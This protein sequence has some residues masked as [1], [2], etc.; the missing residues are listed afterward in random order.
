MSQLQNTAQVFQ[1]NDLV[2]AAKLNA[3]VVQTTITPEVITAQA[4][5]SPAL[6]GWDY[7]LAYEE[8]SGTLVKVDIDTIRATGTGPVKTND[9]ENLGNAD[10]NI[11]NSA[12][13]RT[14]RL[15]SSGVVGTMVFEARNGMMTL[16]TGT[17]TK[18]ANTIVHVS[19]GPF[20]V[21]ESVEARGDSRI[22]NM[23]A[24]LGSPI[25]SFATAGNH[26]QTN[27]NIIE[28]VGPTAEF[29]GVYP[30]TVTSANTFNVTFPI[31]ATVGHVSTA[32]AFRLPTLRVKEFT[33]LNRLQV[34]GASKFVGLAN[35]TSPPQYNG[36]DIK[37]RYDYFAQT[38]DN[39]ILTSGWGGAQNPANLYGT[40]IA[41]LDIT[42][43]PKKAGNTVVLTWSINGESTYSSDTIYLVTRTP[44]TGAGAG[45]AVAL[46]NSVD[47][48]NNTW[49][50]ITLGRD[51]DDSTTPST[52]TV[53]IVDFN[54][55]AV[56]CTYSVH[57]RATNN[58]T[59]TLHL[60]R[61][62]NSAG[63]LDHETGMSVGHAHEIYV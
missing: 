34:V 30:L 41:P 23:T 17:G 47:S 48:S 33:Y 36:A 43:T 24:T 63:A 9:I 44:N 38:R 49:S 45:V 58:R 5:S 14:I 2:T 31:N 53:K 20:V 37:P 21:Q 60:N 26:G 50:G 13:A 42:F 39:S 59:S 19:H 3:L 32:I 40:K 6:T 18:S 51:G 15:T 62:V 1:N 52:Q 29:S 57:F 12:D 10:I 35:F 22:A 46:P 27:G 11:T 61:T 55:L 54:T 4:D 16:A 28:I 56:S 25:V 8:A 7:V